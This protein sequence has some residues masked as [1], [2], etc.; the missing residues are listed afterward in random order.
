MAI[1]TWLPA[2]LGYLI[3]VGLFLLAWGGLPPERARRAATLGALALALAALGYFAVGFAFHL[4]G[5]HLVAPDQPGLEG[6]DSLCCEGWEL[7]GLKGFLLG[8]DADTPQ[9]LAL[10]VSYLP[11]AVTAVL[12]PMLSVSGRARG[13]QVAVGGLVTA[14]VLF[15]L[16][17]CWVWGGGWL[18]RLGSPDS[19]ARGAAA[20]FVAISAGAPFVPPWAALVVGGLAGALLPLS[21]YV[22][23]RVVRLPDET[24]AVSLGV[25]AG[26]LGLLAVPVFADGRW[27][28]GWNGTGQ[29]EYHLVPNLGVVGFFPAAAYGETAG[30]GVGQLVA[31]ATGIGAI[32]ALAILVSWLLFLVMS[33]P[34][35]LRRGRKP[36]MVEAPATDKVDELKP[37]ANVAEFAPLDAVAPHGPEQA[38]GGSAGRAGPES[39]ELEDAAVAGGPKHATTEEPGKAGDPEA[40]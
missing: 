21:V 16:A 27:G 37:A 34:Y 11:L 8:G 18:A 17:A 19:I 25:V 13:W 32:L 2:L 4:G 33:L 29:L 30:D 15:P 3:P 6:L 36:K 12:L 20:G 1:E 10:F 5:A 35:R 39:G 26:L 22:I 7:I 23:E 40:G 14:A 28:Q 24:A 9:A 38:A 31:Q